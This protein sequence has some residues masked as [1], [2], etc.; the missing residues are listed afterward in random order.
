MTD[1]G[2]MNEAMKLFLAHPKI[3]WQTEVNIKPTEITKEKLCV[4]LVKKSRVKKHLVWIIYIL[5]IIQ[6]LAEYE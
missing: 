2:I 5:E 4:Y 3:E 6:I 1:K